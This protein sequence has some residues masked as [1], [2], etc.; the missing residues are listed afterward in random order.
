[1]INRIVREDNLGDAE[2]ADVR[3]QARERLQERLREG[4]LPRDLETLRFVRNAMAHGARPVSAVA[5][6]LL[7]SETALNRFLETLIQELT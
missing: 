1:M 7:A 6:Q 3:E 5:Q 2:N 4:K